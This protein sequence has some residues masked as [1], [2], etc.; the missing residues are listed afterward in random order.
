MAKPSLNISFNPWYY[1]NFRCSFCYLTEQ[2]LS[3]RTLL[4]V[5]VFADRLDALMEHFEI[6]HVDIYGGEVLVLPQ[7]YLIGVKQVLLTRGI[8]DIVLVTNLSHV[9]DIVHDKAFMIS[10]SYDFEAREKHELVLNNMFLLSQRFNVLTLASRAFLDKTTPD[11][12]VETMNMFPHLMGCEIKPYS[13]NQANEHEVSFKE[14]EEFVWAV[15]KHPARKFYFENETQVKEAVEGKRNAFSDDHIYITPSGDFAVLEFDKD[16]REYFL[17]VD[18][19][20]GYLDWCGFERDRV[21]D[22]P[23]C[24]SCP[25]FGNCL[26]EHL[27]E[28]TSLKNSCNGFRGLLDNWAGRKK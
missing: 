6:G 5:D 17:T 24:S 26:S 2:Q 13:T 21:Q 3:D 1:C 4:P 8:T 10:V 28:V 23:F 7:E 20:Q 25:Y 12:Y 16:D 19:V 18:G 22:N 27:R 14:F 9:P 11:D 15:I